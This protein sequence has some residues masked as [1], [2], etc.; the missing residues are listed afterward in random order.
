MI[1]YQ[2]YLDTS[3]PACSSILVGGPV[4]FPPGPRAAHWQLAGGRKYQS[5][6]RPLGHALTLVSVVPKYKSTSIRCSELQHGETRSYPNSSI[7]R[8]PA[9]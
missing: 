7:G 9:P 4:A 5:V 6:G 2:Y 1:M 8:T 3:Y